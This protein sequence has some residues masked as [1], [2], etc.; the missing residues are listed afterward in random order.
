MRSFVFLLACIAGS[1]SAQVSVV[2]PRPDSITLTIYNQG[3]AQVTETRQ[4][5]LPAGPV[6]LVFEGVVDTLLPQSAVMNGAERPLAETNFDFDRLSATALLER[7]VGKT[8]TIVR[9]NR[10]NGDVVREAATILSASGDDGVVIRTVKGNEAFKCSGL[11]ERLE[12]NEIP[13][14]LRTTPTLS[15]RLAAG[16]PGKRS[17]EVSY[18][19]HGMSWSA[20]YVARLNRKS[21]RM[22]LSGWA[23]LIND[24]G[25]SFD[26]AQIQ[27]VSGFLKLQSD[28]DD[29]SRPPRVP[30]VRDFQNRDDEEAGELIDPEPQLPL[31]KCAS[32]PVPEVPVRSG[33]ASAYAT[34][35]AAVDRDEER[36]S[37]TM[38]QMSI[39]NLERL[40]DYFLYRLPEP[41]DLRPHQTKQVLF[42]SK[43]RVKV[44]RVYELRTY[45]FWFDILDPPVPAAALR[46]R[47][48]KSSGLGEPLPHGY[49]RVFE[50]IKG[51]E[52]F[53][54][55]S[56]IG[57]TPEGLDMRVSYADALGVSAES[58]STPEREQS[59]HH[60]S[61]RTAIV[62]HLLTN[63]KNVPVTVFV[64]HMSF[65]SDGISRIIESSLP[66]VSKGG[67]PVW[68]LRMPAGSER[69]LKYTLETDRDSSS[70][71]DEGDHDNDK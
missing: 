24:T 58:S 49:V 41:A 20:D 9:T 64:R 5:D 46:W 26:H 45:D 48:D 51:G 30:R 11:P 59:P 7:S 28:S 47:N 33:G 56:D 16:T 70:L 3:V 63:D 6:T 35:L 57:D 65:Y 42:L 13:D 29:G 1:A 19:V 50:P 52:V 8:V 15:V 54:G 22:H 31:G 68:R 71:S 17:V 55:A 43:P 4:V 53:A 34:I 18:L 69:M 60:Q 25:V 23:T 66:A 39:A 12:F 38:A 62:E 14:N 67:N 36:S 2:S 61:T 37:S 40:G 44:E 27:M 10:R 21:S 32:L